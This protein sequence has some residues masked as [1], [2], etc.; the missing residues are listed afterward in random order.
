M[1]D[2]GAISESVSLGADN[3]IVGICVSRCVSIHV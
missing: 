3:R 2:E 1:M